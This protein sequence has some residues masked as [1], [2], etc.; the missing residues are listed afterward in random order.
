VFLIDILNPCWIYSGAELD[1]VSAI[2]AAVGQLPF[3]FQIG[4]AV[5]QI[6][7]RA[8]ATPEGELEVRLDTCDGERIA[9]LPLRPAAD[10]PA[11]TALAPVAIRPVAGRHDL[12]FTFTQKGVDPMWAIKTVDLLPQAKAPSHGIPDLFHRGGRQ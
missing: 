12:C 5:N 9:V 2:G 1:G 11:V 6:K 10:N 7:F 4:D 3:N 8:P